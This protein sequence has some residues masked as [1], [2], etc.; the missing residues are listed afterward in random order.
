MSELTASDVEIIRGLLKKKANPTEKEL[1]AA[2]GHSIKGIKTKVTNFR[3]KFLDP[4]IPAES[5]A[6]TINTQHHKKPVILPPKLEIKSDPAMISGLPPKMRAKVQMA[7]SP[8]ETMPGFNTNQLQLNQTRSMSADFTRSAIPTIIKLHDNQISPSQRQRNMPEPQVGS[9]AVVYNEHLGQAHICRVL[10]Y[11][12]END[13]KYYLIA[14]FQKEI[15]PCF[16]LRDCLFQL[17][18]GVSF[19]LGDE[20]K[21]KDRI[22]KEDVSVD[23]LLEHIYSAAQNIVLG[24]AYILF[25]AEK[26]AKSEIKPD[27]AMMQQILYQTVKFAA[28]LLLCYISGRWTIPSDKI[29]IIINTV[30]TPSKYESTMKIV[31]EISATLGKLLNLPAK[32]EQKPQQQHPQP[33]P[34][35]N[36]PQQQ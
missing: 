33:V 8:R 7:Q 5:L 34:V 4:S 22:E 13:Q 36:E 2:I 27:Q 9:L 19:P 18:T 15:N 17:E 23:W 3:T 30:M 29:Q 25:P 12:I 28:L 11:K 21:W 32:D 26:I 6:F 16:V 14:F 35:N 24:H 20:S 10:S 31:D 1:T